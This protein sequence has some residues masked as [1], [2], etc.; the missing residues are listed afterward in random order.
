MGRGDGEGGLLII[1]HG[2]RRVTILDQ[3]GGVYS[4]SCMA[5]VVKP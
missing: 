5:V 2:R 3:G 4:I 1:M